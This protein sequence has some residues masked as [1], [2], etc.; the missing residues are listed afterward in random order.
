MARTNTSP[1]EAIVLDREKIIDQWKNET[2]F[3]ANDGRK[4]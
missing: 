2:Y 4:D 3:A 1:V